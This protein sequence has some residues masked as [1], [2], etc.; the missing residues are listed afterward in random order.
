VLPVS[1]CHQVF[2]NHKEQ[3]RSLQRHPAA[4]SRNLPA[5]GSWSQDCRGM[6]EATWQ[7]RSQV[8]VRQS[9][10]LVPSVEFRLWAFTLSTRV[11]RREPLC[12]SEGS[13]SCTRPRT[14]QITSNHSTFRTLFIVSVSNSWELSYLTGSQS[15]NR[16]KVGVKYGMHNFAMK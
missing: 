15:H 8:T 3:L 7:W 1:A 12:T 5:G 4:S 13:R 11:S 9:P 6:P 16:D 14:V 10:Y 2:V